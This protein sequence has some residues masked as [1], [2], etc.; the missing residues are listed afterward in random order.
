M[1][2]KLHRSKRLK[3]F[4]LPD[5]REV[6]IALSPEEAVSMKQRLEAIRDNDTFD[7]VINGSPEHI[8]AL[9]KAYSHH[10]ERRHALREKHGE[11]YDE[12]ERMREDLDALSIDLH[13]LTDHAV[14][15]D[16]NFSKYG[17]NAH[18]R[19]YDDPLE[20]GGSSM[21]AHDDSDHESK[22]W[23]AERKNGRIFKLY[24]KPVVR[25]YFHRGLLWRA[26][27]TTEVATFELFLDLLYVGII[28]INGDSAAETPTGNGLN[29]FAI[30]FIMSWRIWRSA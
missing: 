26:S 2:G 3:S 7:L 1:G 28:A 23:E 25:Q 12:I 14:S 16:A 9:R 13:M 29:R 24:K 8:E 22:D 6:H 18:L 19:T 5:G 10:E 4:S 20:S 17:Y 27:N 15:L 21:H 30:T 11:T